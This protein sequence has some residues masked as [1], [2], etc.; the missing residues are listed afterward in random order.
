[1]AESIPFNECHDR[2]QGS[3]QLQPS[4]DIE[5]LERVAEIK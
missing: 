1:L 3:F 4:V 2:Q 5:A